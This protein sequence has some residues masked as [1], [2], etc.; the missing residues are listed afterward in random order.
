[1]QLLLDRID[2][3]DPDADEVGPDQD[4]ILDLM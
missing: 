1:M 4:Q 3:A 2:T